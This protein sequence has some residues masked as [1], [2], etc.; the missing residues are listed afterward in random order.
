MS[1]FSQ[2]LKSNHNFTLHSCEERPGIL[3][4]QVL[5]KQGSQPVGCDPLSG[6]TAFHSGHI[7]GIHMTI[8]DQQNYSY[9]VAAKM[10]LW[11][12][13]TTT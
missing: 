3:Q 9:E 11:L 1:Y 6:Q 5:L 4:F 2:G 13:V 7:L 10:I 12:G 8:H